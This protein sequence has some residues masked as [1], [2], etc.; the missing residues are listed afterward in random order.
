LCELAWK[1][2]CMCANSEVLN[3]YLEKVVLFSDHKSQ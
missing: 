3:G 1:S 2:V